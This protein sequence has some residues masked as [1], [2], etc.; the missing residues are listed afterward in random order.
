VRARVKPADW[1]AAVSSAEATVQIWI[2]IVGSSPLA[3]PSS[4]DAQLEQSFFCAVAKLFRVWHL[5]QETRFEL[6]IL[7][8]MKMAA[9]WYVTTCSD[10]S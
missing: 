9:F 1:L 3:M 7:L 10:L 4:A 5:T 2:L 8:G 6:L